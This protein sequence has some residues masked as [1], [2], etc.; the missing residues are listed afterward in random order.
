MNTIINAES[1]INCDISCRLTSELMR[2]RKSTIIHELVEKII[3]TEETDKGYSFTF[4]YSEEILFRLAEF[5]KLEKECCPFFDF[6]LSVPGNINTIGLLLTGPDGTK[7]FI[8]YE[9]EM[10]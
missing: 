7:D 8:K 1:N 10:I 4:N 6:N 9:L 3:M 2:K 5:V